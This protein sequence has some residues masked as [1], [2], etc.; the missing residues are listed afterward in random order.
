MAGQ[1]YI[2]HFR[3]IQ[4]NLGAGTLSALADYFRWLALLVLLS[5]GLVFVARTLRKK[6]LRAEESPFQA[7]DQDGSQEEE[8]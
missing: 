3:E 2:L 7:P 4:L 5:L 8:N 1:P 6:K